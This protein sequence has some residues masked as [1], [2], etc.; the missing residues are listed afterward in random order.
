MSSPVLISTAVALLFFA[1]NSLLCRLALLGNHIDAGSFTALRLAS[2]AIALTFILLS[3]EG[4]SVRFRGGWISAFALFAYAAP[5][6]FAYLDL[7]VGTGALILFGSVQAT[8][9]GW[10]IW[11]GGRPPVLEWVGLVLALG[12]LAGLVAPG[13]SAPP[14]LASGL[15]AV[16]GISWGVYSLRGKFS[17]D[18][19]SDTAGNF[20][21]SVPFILLLTP[22]SAPVLHVSERGILLAVASGALASGVGYAV[23]YRALTGLTSTRAAIVQLLVPAFAAVAGVVVLGEKVTARLIL[24][25]CLIFAGVILALRKNR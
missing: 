16:A 2:G 15:M 5:F 12:G 7:P 1:S 20:L 21:R 6:S 18:P 11:K 3:K 22:W 10:D 4:R 13:L 25:A 8:M 23:W 24:S 17:S 9:I 19:I 14:L